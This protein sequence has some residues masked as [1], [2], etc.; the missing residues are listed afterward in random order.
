MAI[1]LRLDGKLTLK[2]TEVYRYFCVY[3]IK[4]SGIDWY[5]FLFFKEKTF[6]Y[7]SFTAYTRISSVFKN[8]KKSD[9]KREK[10]NRVL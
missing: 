2:E 1:L 7:I 10:G 3:L 6:L 9:I 8:K 4:K 5:I